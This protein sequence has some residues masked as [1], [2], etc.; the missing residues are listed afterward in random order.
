MP[1][2]TVLFIMSRQT[3]LTL[4]LAFPQANVVCVVYDVSEEATIEK[5]SERETLLLLVHSQPDC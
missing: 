3:L 2:W 1:E 4:Y 5:V